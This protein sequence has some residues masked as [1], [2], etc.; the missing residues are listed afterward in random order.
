MDLRKDAARH[1]LIT[2][3]LAYLGAPY[4]WGGDDPSGFDCSGLVIE[5]LQSVG[6][7]EKV[8]L[9]ADGLMKRFLS[10]QTSEPDCGCLVFLIDASNRACHVGICLDKWFMIE[11]GGGDNSV[12]DNA[13]AWRQNAFV[14]IR[15]LPSPG[16]RRKFCDPFL[17]IKE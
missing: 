9:S 6:L 10:C 7:L 8:D 4:R 1:W 2:T 11:A 3:A 13:V 16:P 17:T 5:A 12:V 14:K 15:P